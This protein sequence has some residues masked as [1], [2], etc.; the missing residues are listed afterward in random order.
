MKES[1]NLRLRVPV[2]LC[3][4]REQ[5]STKAGLDGGT[6]LSGGEENGGLRLRG[7]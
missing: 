6:G 3:L 7:V 2:R 1:V 5:R 4:F